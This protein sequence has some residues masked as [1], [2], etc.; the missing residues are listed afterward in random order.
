MGHLDPKGV[1]G[2]LDVGLEFGPPV[3]C[4][5]G[6]P[7]GDT[8]ISRREVCFFSEPLGP[9]VNR[10]GGKLHA[11]SHLANVQAG[12]EKGDGSA[13]ATVRV[14]YG[15]EGLQAGMLGESLRE[16]GLALCVESVPEPA[17]GS[18]DLTLPAVQLGHLRPKRAAKRLGVDHGE[19]AMVIGHPRNPD[20]DATNALLLQKGVDARHDH[21][22]VILIRAVKNL[23]NLG[24]PGPKRLLA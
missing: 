5:Q 19:A 11:A 10:A 2:V 22:V 8:I 18:I 4:S 14:G 21:L 23:A 12:E 20:L 16:Q 15:Q 1:E 13:F 7:G 24:H 3:L 17:N 6:L 9:A